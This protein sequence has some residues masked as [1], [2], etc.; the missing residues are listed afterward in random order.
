MNGEPDDIQL[1]FDGDPVKRLRGA[2]ADAVIN[3]LTALQRMLLIIGMRAE[4]RGLGQRLKATA[5]VKREYSLICKAPKFGSHLQPFNIASQS[6]HF[7]PAAFSART[8]LLAAL[9]AFDSGDGELVAQ[10]LPDPRERWFLANAA[11]GLI[12]DEDS[13]L[14]VTVRAGSRGPFTFKAD[15]ARKIISHI[16]S[17]PVPDS[18]SEEVVGKVQTINYGQTILILKPAQSRAV[19][20]DYPLPLEPMLQANVRKRLKLVGYPNFNNAGDITGFRELSSVVEV[21]P[22]LEPISEFQSGKHKVFAS[23]SMA[24]LVAFD[25]ETRLFLYQNP[26]L[27]VDVFSE[28]YGHIRSAILEELD[29][30]W[31]NYACASDDELAPDAIA[32]KASLNSYFKVGS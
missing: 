7:S 13:G 25:H 29:V 10:V 26:L 4:G 15:R 2:P 31:R 16:R 11:S 12:P 17:G 27:G 24:I 5:K 8:K 28:S 6:G 18:G 19:R 22:S 1:K 23:R 3:S 21:E 20:M 30:L 9:K 32:L 14:D